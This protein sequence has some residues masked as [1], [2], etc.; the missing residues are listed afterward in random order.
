MKIAICDDEQAQTQYLSALVK[1]WATLH[2]N[3]VRIETFN[4]AEAFQFSW[5]EDR[6][7]DLLL[8]DIKMPGKNGMELAIAIRQ[9]DGHLALLFIT[10]FPDFLAEGYDVDALNYLIKPIDEEKFFAVLDKAAAR[11]CTSPRS[12]LLPVAGGNL[13]IPAEEI[14]Y[15]EAFSHTIELY[16]TRQSCTVKVS[17]NELEALLGEGFF[18]CHRSYIVNVKHLRRVSRT[19]L[20]LDT[21]KEIPLSRKLYDEANQVFIRYC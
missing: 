1:K 8:L 18:R 21:G 7:Y 20:L 2:G 10:G 19:V 6:S 9:R 15:A 11:V 14:L 12:I 5:C 17:M 13:R 4:S 3:Q 16:S